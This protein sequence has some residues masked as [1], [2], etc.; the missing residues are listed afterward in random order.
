MSEKEAA[1]SR[2]FLLALVSQLRGN[3][4]DARDV[5][6]VIER[7]VPVLVPGLVA[8]DAV[9]L[10]VVFAPVLHSLAH[11]RCCCFTTS[12]SLVATSDGPSPKDH[13][14]ERATRARRRAARAA[15][16][17]DRPPRQVPLSPQPAPYRACTIR[18]IVCT[19]TSMRCADECAHTSSFEHFIE[20]TLRRSSSKTWRAVSFANSDCMLPSSYTHVAHTLFALLCTCVVPVSAMS[21]TM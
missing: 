18:H 8:P 4:L 13:D 15:D 5:E 2:E 20:R 10:P 1:A 6:M 14:R 9:V 17:A 7:L 16:Q 21:R 19:T 3:G 11:T 12:P